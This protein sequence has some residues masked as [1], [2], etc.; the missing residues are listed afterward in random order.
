MVK[1]FFSVIGGLIAVFCG[2]VFALSSPV[3]LA[4]TLLAVLVIGGL[5]V[6]IEG[7]GGTKRDRYQ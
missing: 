5:L 3:L 2:V 7:K 1:T 4:I 6:A